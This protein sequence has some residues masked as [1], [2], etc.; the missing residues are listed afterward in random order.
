VSCPIFAKY[1]ERNKLVIYGGGVHLSK[2]FIIL[3]D[4][5]K[6]FGQI[7]LHQDDD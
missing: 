1:P 3:D 4:G 6:S 5:S 2:D 7:T